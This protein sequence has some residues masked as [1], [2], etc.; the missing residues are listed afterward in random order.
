MEHGLLDPTSLHHLL[1]HA[2]DRSDDLVVVLER[3]GDGADHLVIAAINDA[4]RRAS[5][6]AATELIGRPLLALA[7]PDASPATCRELLAAADQH[8]S[9]RSELLCARRGGAPFWLGL[10]LIPG[11]ISGATRFVLL[12]RD[13]TD[14]LQARQQQAAIQGLL[15]KVFLCVQVPV[16][17]VDEHGMILMANPAVER[18]FGWPSSYLAGKGAKDLIAP[19]ARAAAVSARDRQMATSQDYTIPSVVL[20]ADG[21]EIPVE[22]TSVI[23]QR[24]DLKRFRIITLTRREAANA[25][26]SN[27]PVPAAPGAVQVAGKIRLV[28]L[29]EVKTALGARWETVATRA[30]ASAEH[31]VRRRCGPCDS[32]SRTG[33]DGFL[34]CFGDAT[35]DEAAF[36][37]A[38]I[39][40]EVRA[41]LIGAGETPAVAEVSAIAGTVE[42]PFG[43]D[44]SPDLLATVISERL[45][46][47]L[48][49]I[50][51][52]ARATLREL[53]QMATCELQPVRGQ[54]GGEPLAQF[55][56]LPRA[57]ERRAQCALAALP[58]RECRAFDFD[59][60]MLGVAASEAVAQLAAGGSL[61]IL[62]DVD[63]ELFHDRQCAERYVAACH[64][65]DVRLRQRL[66]LILT[67]LP[68]ATPR[69][70]VSECVMRLRPFCHGVGFQSDA[71]HAPPV[72]LALLGGAIVAVPADSF[73]L[74]DPDDLAKLR[75]L[76]DLVRTHHA[77]VLVRQASAPEGVRRLLQMGVELVSLSQEDS[78]PG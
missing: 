9:F 34:I 47:Q 28:G 45:N 51:V 22:L 64:A 1:S 21:S 26:A 66:I 33:D 60:L 59:R 4:F 53:A 20:H 69:S 75:K 7:A 16:A 5:G 12:G 54:R 48:A 30:M 14:R 31:V 18:L 71:L 68:H 35:E 63:F 73:S 10:H 61:P 67:H 29:Q 36:R 49:R 23:V 50:E 74:G 24:D 58:P 78:L 72:E 40:R 3:T 70:R 8:L 15:A 44:R 57:L 37:A 42:V 27:A 11:A 13:I 65:L 32:Y 43:N 2:L 77:R 39:A 52:Q 62:V 46:G 17:I 25:S 19:S 41:R 55:A 56:V 76:I 38:T 6:Y